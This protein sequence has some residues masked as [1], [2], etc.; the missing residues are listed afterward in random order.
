MAIPKHES[1]EIEF[2]E[3]DVLKIGDGFALVT[4]VGNPE[5]NLE[6]SV[7]GLYNPNTPDEEVRYNRFTIRPEN[8]RDSSFKRLDIALPN[9]KDLRRWKYRTGEGN[10]AVLL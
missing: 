5:L 2:S 6:T 4:K 1:N 7:V 9:K 10:L 8:E 3:G